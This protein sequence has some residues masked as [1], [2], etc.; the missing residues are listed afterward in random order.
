MLHH[1][2]GAA[3]VVGTLVGAEVAGTAVAAPVTTHSTNFEGFSLGS[4]NGQGGWGVSNPL[5]DQE[6][7][8]LAGNRVLRL[9]NRYTSG[10]FSDQTFAPR[11]GGIPTPPA[12]PVSS[13]PGFFAGETSTGA[14]Y[15]R[16]IGSFEIRSVATG[17]TDRGARIT[18]SPD[19]GQGARQGFVAF[20]NTATG[21]AVTTFDLTAG[22]SFVGPETL[23]TINFGVWAKIR[24]EIDFIDGPF[25]DVARIYIDDVL[26]K[27]LHSWES[28][29]PVVQPTLHP[30]GVPVQ[31]WLFRMSGTAAPNAQ[32]FYIDN[33]TVMLDNIATA[34]PEPA[35]LALLGLG[36]AGLA[37][38][39]RRA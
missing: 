21:V 30:N 17:D 4:V 33:V 24:Y 35:S 39:R 20:E 11:P 6:V 22:G 10:S 16:F 12:N 23:T 26:V 31:T 15:N 29:Y 9:S 8:D 25:N 18:V 27:T 3:L 37:F 14:S 19:N 36:L 1:M 38:A 5:F 7:V 34:V 2:I 32:G 28:Y 13:N